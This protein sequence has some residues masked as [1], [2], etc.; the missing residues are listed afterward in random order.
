MQSFPNDI[1]HLTVEWQSKA[2]ATWC[3][4]FVLLAYFS[5]PLQVPAHSSIL[6]SHIRRNASSI[7]G[8]A[9]RQ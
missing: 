7:K 2:L 6:S 3:K 5:R 8:A 4:S 9:P 1:V